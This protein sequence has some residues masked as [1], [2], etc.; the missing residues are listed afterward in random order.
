[1][2]H[3]RQTTTMTPR[4]GSGRSRPTTRPGAP[5]RPH[6]SPAPVVVETET[7][8][9]DLDGDGVLDA[10][11]TVETVVPV[12]NPTQAPQTITTLWAEIGDD[13]AP[14]RVLTSS[15]AP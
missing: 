13:G 14:R 8:Y 12:D 15:V 4:F 3:D 10:V 9:L 2:R 1:M 11:E 5:S 6:A 7:R